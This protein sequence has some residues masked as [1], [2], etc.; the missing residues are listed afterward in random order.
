M[1]CVA[2]SDPE[3]HAHPSFVNVV[4]VTLD[5]AVTMQI[6]RG[7]F[8]IVHVEC[9]F[10]R[11]RDSAFSAIESEIPAAAAVITVVD[12]E[13]ASKEHTKC[14]VGV[15]F[16]EVTVLSKKEEKKKKRVCNCL[17]DAVTI[18]SP[19]NSLRCRLTD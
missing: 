7:V 14:S 3:S 16:N 4:A 11:S 10:N 15:I 13:V 6:L 18:L 2:A 19:V 1:A 12:P 8:A 5:M 9:T 17:G